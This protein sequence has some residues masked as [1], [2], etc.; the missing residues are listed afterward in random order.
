M[1]KRER[2]IRSSL[3]KHFSFIEKM[4]YEIVGVFLQGSQNYNNDINDRD[5]Q[6][7]IDTKA[8]VLPSFD[9]FA[10]CRSEVSSSLSV[11]GE[12]SDVKD[13]RIMFQNFK[14]MNI[15]FLEILFT[16][17]KIINPKYEKEVKE[18]LD[19]AENIASYN[20][21][22]LFNSIIGMSKQKLVALKHSYPS[23]LEKIEKFGYDP[24]QL[25]HI[26]RLNFFI[27]KLIAG[28]TFRECLDEKENKKFLKKIKKGKLSLEEAE[29]LAQEID[30]ETFKLREEYF[31]KN[32]ESL[33]VNG[34]VSDFLDLVAI[35]ILKKKFKE[36]LKDE[37]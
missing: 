35:K 11:L 18:L 33:V 4:G 22:A 32:E 2:L 3:E 12:K 7:D 31:K 6:S 1:D 28:K 37:E 17:W 16:E 21:K 5:Y 10:K 36:D 9:D 25:A 13:I 14:K 34:E 20:K 19:N 29:I 30:E 24:K 23:T 8:I 15:N 27:K 26:L